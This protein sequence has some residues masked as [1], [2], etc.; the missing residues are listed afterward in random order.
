M[1]MNQ[2]R[3]DMP[4]RKRSKLVLPS[5]QTTDVE[6]EE[7]VK[8]GQSAEAAA[9]VA[10]QDGGANLLQDY[11]QTPSAQLQARTPRAPSSEDPLLR[12]AQNIIAL[13][14]TESVLEGGENTPL[15]DGGGSF[16]GVTPVRC[17]RFAYQPL[18][19]VW[20][21]AVMFVRKPAAILSGSVSTM[22]DCGST[23]PQIDFDPE[24]GPLDPVPCCKCLSHPRARDWHRSACFDPAQGCTCHQY[25]DGLDA[26]HPAVAR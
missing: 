18:P 19:V 24:Y 22:P 12:E 16:A 8:M 26:A 5:P 15:H 25:R 4:Q 10:A 2:I 11:S 7:L 21:G 9:A 3:D 17:V 13:N 14:Q 1:Q 23:G 20:Q 6:L